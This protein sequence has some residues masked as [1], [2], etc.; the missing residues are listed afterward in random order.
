MV[1][2]DSVTSVANNI[3]ATQFHM[4]KTLAIGMFL[5]LVS[6][7]G[8]G[9]S[10]SVTV[11]GVVAPQANILKITDDGYGLLTPNFYYSTDNAAFW[12]IQA[13]VANGIDDQNF[14]TIIRIDIQKTDSGRMPALNK[15]YSIEDNPAYETFPGVFSVFNGQGSV[16]NRVEQGTISFT[17]D[18]DPSREVHGVFDVTITHYDSK[19]IPPPQYNI[20]GIFSFNMGTYGAAVP[21]VAGIYPAGGK[22]AFDNFC[23]SCHSLGDY[24]PAAKSAAD[25]A[26]RGCELSQVYPGTFPEHQRLTLDAQTIQDLKVF[27]NA[28]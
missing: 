20:K 14:R 5:M 8:G 1:T 13:D 21:P 12:S 27:L 17:P 24:A 18:S 10:S 23:S 3:F 25:L 16:C 28:W 7:G 11:A 19:L 4:L 15:T 2:Q 9:G 22:E 6:C 26:Q